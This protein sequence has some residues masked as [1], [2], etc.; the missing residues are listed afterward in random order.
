MYATVLIK[1]TT[2]AECLRAIVTLVWALTSVRAIVNLKMTRCVEHLEARVALVL[3]FAEITFFR[4]FANVLLEV[5]T[6]GKAFI[7]L[8]AS[9]FG[10]I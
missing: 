9:E 2:A 1:C 10:R 4:V 6:A 3:L 7:T 5:V 8:S